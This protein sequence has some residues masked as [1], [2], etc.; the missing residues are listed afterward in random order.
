MGLEGG[1]CYPVGTHGA[2]VQSPGSTEGEGGYGENPRSVRGR[3]Y[4]SHRGQ[5]MS[6]VRPPGTWCDPWGGNRAIA[7]RTRY[8]AILALG[9]SRD[10]ALGEDRGW[11]GGT[12]L[13]FAVGWETRIGEGM[14]KGR[15][16]SYL[17]ALRAGLEAGEVL[18]PGLK[19]SY[20]PLGIS[21][22]P[23]RSGRLSRRGST[24][25]PPRRPP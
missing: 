20:C 8:G 18:S 22:P 10:W 5:D 14:K 12:A 11:R 1:R 3:S 9:G 24:F 23:G 2:R 13:Q 4:S 6:T 15:P 21:A 25:W 16:G 19:R 17:G 7:P